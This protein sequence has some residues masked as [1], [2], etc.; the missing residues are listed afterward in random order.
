MEDDEGLVDSAFAGVSVVANAAP[1]VEV[2]H[3]DQPND[4]SKGF[5]ATTAWGKTTY[6]YARATDPDG[7]IHSTGIT[8]DPGDDNLSQGDRGQARA[9]YT[10]GAEGETITVRASARDNEGA[11]TEVVRTVRVVPPPCEAERVVTIERL[12]AKAVC[13]RRETR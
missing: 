12:R 5:A 6:Y 1:V 13:W 9:Y 8:L 3:S 4:S 2:F 11:V 7:T 10:A